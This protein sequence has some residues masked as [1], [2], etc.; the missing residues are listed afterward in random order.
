MNKQ[1]KGTNKMKKTYKV[2]VWTEE[3]TLLDFVLIEAKTENEAEQKAFK[4][5]LDVLTVESSVEAK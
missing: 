1:N 3:G 4:M 5:G 2:I